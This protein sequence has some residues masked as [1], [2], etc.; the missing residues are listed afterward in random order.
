MRC[1]ALAEQ[2]RRKNVNILFVCREHD[3]NLNDIITKNGFA[4]YRLGFEQPLKNEETSIEEVED[5]RAPSA[6]SAWLGV[7]QASDACQTIEALKMDAPWDW[8]IVDHYSL[9]YS[10]EADMLKVSNKIMVID[11]LADRKHDCDLLMDQNYFQNPAVRY[12]GL[13]PEHSEKLFG[14]Q[15]ALLRE[16]FRHARKFCSMRGNGVGRILVYFGGYDFDNLTGMSLEALNSPELI[17]LLVD[18]VIGFNNPHLKELA[19]QVQSRAGTRLHIQPEGFVELMLRADICIG[20]G[21][22]T[23]WERLSLALPSLVITV[24]ENQE[25]F[26]ECLDKAGYITWIGTKE[27]IATSDIR[28]SILCAIDKLRDQEPF[29]NSPNPVDGFGA[30]KIA[31]KLVPASK[32][33]LSL[34]KAGKGDME[35]YFLWANDPVV[36]ENSFQ[37]KPITWQEHFSWFNKKTSSG[38]TEMWVLKTALGLPVGQIRF[39]INNETADISYCLDSMVRERGWGSHLIKLGINKI[40]SFRNLKMI[41]ARVKKDNLASRNIFLKL[42]FKANNENEKIIF[43]KKIND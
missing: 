39:D 7:D 35:Q 38:L 5:I 11:D 37:Q 25:P 19:K 16:E 42:D 33:E 29:S 40:V 22:V 6:Y 20:A 14:P 18:V 28:N 1:L 41:Q 27:N 23:T 10:W 2:F 26:T 17:H 24:A 21:G 13:V 36:R 9:G 31:E 8:I 34:R 12:K 4:I 43:R 32:R 3:G 30:L 15:Y